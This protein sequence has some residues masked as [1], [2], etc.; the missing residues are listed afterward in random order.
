MNDLKVV[1]CNLYVY[2]GSPF[3]S[4]G[5]ISSA[6]KAHANVKMTHVLKVVSFI[7]K[8]NGVPLFVKKRVVEEALMS[9]LV[10]G[11]QSWIGPHLKPV[12]KLYN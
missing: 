7:N 8:N 4:D 2:L 12:I 11:C 10:Y 1:H 6:V 5:S 9:S 3:T